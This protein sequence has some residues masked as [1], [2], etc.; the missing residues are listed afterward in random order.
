LGVKI[1]KFFDEDPGSGMEAVRIRDPGWK[2]VGSGIRDKHPGSATLHP[3]FQNMNFKK[4]KSTFVESGS[5]DL[6]ESGSGS[7]TLAFHLG[8]YNRSFLKKHSFFWLPHL[9]HFYCHMIILHFVSG[10]RLPE[11]SLVVVFTCRSSKRFQL[12]INL[13]ENECFL[14]CCC[15]PCSLSIVVSGTGTSMGA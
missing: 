1:L 6:I 3:T 15:L 7:A 11:H 9:L 2:K 10:L 4:K 8:L 14:C 13:N 12:S 5:T